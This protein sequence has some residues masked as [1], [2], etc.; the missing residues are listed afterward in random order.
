MDATAERGG[1]LLATLQR[2]LESPAADLNV[3]LS[4]AADAVADALRADKVD[5]FVHDPMR[6]SLVAVGVSH[7]PLSG[8]E[9]RLGLD[10]LPLANGGRVVHVFNTGET[11]TTGRLDQDVDELRGVRE[12]MKI[13]SKIGVP[14]EIG[15][16]RRGMM[17]IASLQPEF[18][19]QDDVRFA[20]SVRAGWAAWRTAP[21]WSRR[22]LV[23]RT[24]RAG[25]R[26]PK[27]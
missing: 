23:T 1:R 12:A 26:S 5:A 20:E 13:K 15:G 8:L 6:D 16:K 18:F 4:H 27:S 25:A 19:D 14:L 7:Q 2:L 24:S 9:R 17:M 11:F 22:S 3:A 10:V 21:N